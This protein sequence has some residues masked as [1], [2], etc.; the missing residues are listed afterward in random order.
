[1]RLLICRF[2]ICKFAHNGVMLRFWHIFLSQ[3]FHHGSVFRLGLCKDWLEVHWPRCMVEADLLWPL[4]RE[5]DL[6][7]TLHRE[8]VVPNTLANPLPVALTRRLRF[9]WQEQEFFHWHWCP[10]SNGRERVDLAWQRSGY[11]H[12][13]RWIQRP[14]LLTRCSANKQTIVSCVSGV[15]QA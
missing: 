5:A 10:S 12:L 14:R 2:F 15:R 9:R 11:Q 6:L 4:R 8:E 3:Y 1:M 13:W 7:W